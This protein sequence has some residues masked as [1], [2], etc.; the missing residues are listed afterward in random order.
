MADGTVRVAC[1][2]ASGFGWDRWLGSRGAFVGMRA[3]PNH[4]LVQ[5]GDRFVNLAADLGVRD[6][7]G[8]GR[9]VN[10]LDFDGDGDLDLFVGNKRRDGHPDALFRN[11]GDGFARV[12]SAVSSAGTSTTGSSWSDWDRDGDPDLLVTQ[13]GERPPRAWRKPFFLAR[14]LQ[15]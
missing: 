12:D 7:F 5:R 9:S 13:Y 3:G 14:R 11:H 15:R 8:R 2:A 10:W 6:K 4:L 1:E